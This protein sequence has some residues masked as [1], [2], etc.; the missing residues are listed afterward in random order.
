[1]KLKITSFDIGKAAISWWTFHF[2]VDL[3]ESIR[4]VSK[5]HGVSTEVSVSN[6]ESLHLSDS[7]IAKDGRGD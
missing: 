7:E 1:M 3:P 2:L 4:E 6:N 5:F